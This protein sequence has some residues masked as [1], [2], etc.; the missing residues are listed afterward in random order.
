MKKSLLNRVAAAAIAVPVALSQT[1]LFASFADVANTAAAPVAGDTNSKTL[2]IETLTSVPTDNDVAPIE[3]VSVEGDLYTFQQK[4]NWNEQLQAALDV[5]ANTTTEINVQDLVKDVDAVNSRWYAQSALEAVTDCNVRVRASSIVITLGA[6]YALGDE[7]LTNRLKKSMV[8]GGI[9]EEDAAEIL[10]VNTRVGGEGVIT[11]YTDSI[12]QKKFTGTLE[13]T[14]DD[15]NPLE[16]VDEIKDY[17]EKRLDDLRDEIIKNTEAKKAAY[18]AELDA[19]KAAGADTKEAQDKLDGANELIDKKIAEE[20][21]K[22]HDRVMNNVEKLTNKLVNADKNGTYT[23]T[24]EEVWEQAA[25]K[26]D[27]IPATLSELGSDETINKI[28]DAVINQLS[29]VATDKGVAVDLSLSDVATAIASAE[30]V[31]VNVNAADGEYSLEVVQAELPDYEGAANVDYYYTYFNELLASE[32]KTVVPGT[33]ATVLNAE[34]AVNTSSNDFT[35]DAAFDIIRTITFRVET[36]EGTTEPSEEET[37]EPETDEPTQAP[38]DEVPTEPETDEPTE[39]ETAEPTE[40]TPTDETPTDETPTDET[41]TD[42]TPTDETPTDETPTDETPT[43]ETPT[44]ETPT[45]ETPT[46]ETPTDETP[47]DET[48]TDETPTD[49]T[50]TDETPTDEPTEPTAPTDEPTEPTAPTD[51]PTAPTDE[52]TAPT[53]EPTAPTDEPTAPTD[54]PTEPTE[55]PTTVEVEIEVTPLKN[56]FFFSHDVRPLSLAELI[57]EA[58]VTIYY[59]DEKGADIDSEEVAL[60]LTNEEDLAK[61][62]VGTN[63]S[64]PADENTIVSPASI[65]EAYKA[66]LDDPEKATYTTTNIYIY[67]VG[68]EVDTPVLA[69]D[70]ATLFVGVKGDAN[71]DGKCNAND[72]AK[73]L[74]YAADYGAMKNPS[75]SNLE[76]ET[77]EN[78][79]Y[80]LADVNGESKVKPTVDEVKEDVSKALNANDAN[81]ILVHSA[82]RG[83]KKDPQWGRTVLPTSN[84]PAVTKAIIAYLDANPDVKHVEEM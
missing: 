36:E 68:D 4:S 44:D 47:T 64:G 71:L 12:D 6:D 2:S 23:G 50:P 29:A 3:Q 11:I 73:V 9:P 61:L 1:V 45:D 18:Q 78:F 21:A 7:S 38:S 26:N 77:L 54:E 14:D 76:D 81:M 79:V 33:I 35:G 42:E 27:R 17:A 75:I 5:M 74:K 25:A 63:T 41:P 24:G 49:E 83:A 51:E 72:G 70:T 66:T 82:Q 55:A 28:F 84:L 69:V 10:D 48:P 53:D 65:Y 59:V 58:K 37:T 30:N 31:E 46:D 60:D 80:F 40:E 67:Y 52:P 43:D 62:A 16:T 15:R 39:P 13:I 8:N 20:F 32:G 22:L 57:S 34:A 56:D 19:A